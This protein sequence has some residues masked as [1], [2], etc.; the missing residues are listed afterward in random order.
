VS[1]VDPKAIARLESLPIKAQVI[2]EG[3]LTGLHRSRH[4]G[5]SVEFAE[6]KEYSPG[7]E[8]RHIDW[9]A[10]GKLD[11]YYVKQFEQE[12]QLTANLLLDASGS[13]AFEGGGL[14]K[15]DYAS[16]LVASLAYLLI[17]QR[18]RVGLSVFGNP[19][20]EGYVPPR[21]RP[22]HLHDLLTVIDGVAGAGATGDEPAGAALE[23]IGELSRRR[24]SLIVLASDLFEPE[25]GALTTLRQLKA[26]GHDVAVF[27]VLDPHEIDFP[28]EGLTLFEAL[29]DDRKMLVNPAA[30]RREYTRKMQGFL[31]TAREICTSGGV[32]YHLVRTDE[33]L[34][35]SLLSFLTLRATSA[36]RPRVWSS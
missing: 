22:R 30:I 8:V 10:Y 36:A 12:A 11:R 21:A 6:H 25:D 17:R 27:H 29:E 3:A 5:S 9:K 35:Q 15:L 18:D 7:D 31:E 32:E 20:F 26:Q 16:Y 24:R 14:R 34:E 2:V 4:H 33:P 28:Y 13:M 19:K 1:F 23:R